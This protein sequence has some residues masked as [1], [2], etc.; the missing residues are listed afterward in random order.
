MKK[1]RPADAEEKEN[2]KQEESSGK[3]SESGEKVKSEK[4]TGKFEEREDRTINEEK[5]DGGKSLVV[6]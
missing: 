1:R 3:E 2:V 4:E 5:E 6:E